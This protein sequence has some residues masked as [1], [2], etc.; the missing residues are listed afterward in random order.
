M[1]QYVKTRVAQTTSTF[2]ETN[3]QI[4]NALEDISQAGGMNLFFAHNFV[5]VL[6]GYKQKLETNHCLPPFFAVD[7]LN[8]RGFVD[9]IMIKHFSVS[10]A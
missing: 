1:T 9:V 6:R 8:K 4:L 2:D 3:F 7:R 5:S 10:L